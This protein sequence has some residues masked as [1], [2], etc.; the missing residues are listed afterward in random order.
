MLEPKDAAECA[1]IANDEMANLVAKHPDR[2]CGA[3][4]SLPMNFCSTREKDRAGKDLRF[5]GVEGFTDHNGQPGV[6]RD[7]A[8]F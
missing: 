7:L 6:R 3:C 5:R 2:F 4:A 8:A 1:R